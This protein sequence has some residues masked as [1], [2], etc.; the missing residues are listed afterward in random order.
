MPLNLAIIMIY[1][2]KTIKGPLGCLWFSCTML[3]FL[4]QYIVY[5]FDEIMYCL[6]MHENFEQDL[7]HNRYTFYHI[8]S[9]YLLFQKSQNSTLQW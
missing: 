5:R 8:I 6:R 9:Q 2:A 4:S 1:S 3:S 7:T